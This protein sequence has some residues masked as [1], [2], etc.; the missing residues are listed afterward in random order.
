MLNRRID[1][2]LKLVEIK[3]S[4]LPHLSWQ[5]KVFHVQELFDLVYF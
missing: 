4:C 2:P 3:C 5:Y 1:A